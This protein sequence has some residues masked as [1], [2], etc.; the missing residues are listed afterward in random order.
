MVK[1]HTWRSDKNCGFF[2]IGQFLEASTFYT[3]FGF[4]FLNLYVKLHF[5]SKILNIQGGGE[6]T[7]SPTVFGSQ[8]WLKTEPKK[9]VQSTSDLV[10]LLVNPKS[11]TKSKVV[12]KSI[13]CIQGTKLEVAFTTLVLGRILFQLQF[14][15]QFK[16]KPPL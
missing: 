15:C 2:I 7:L 9:Q 5:S 11:V 12:T 1:F 8:K 10:T 3:E 13:V 16:I 6:G 4:S 14:L